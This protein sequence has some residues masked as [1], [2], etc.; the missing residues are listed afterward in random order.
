MKFLEGRLEDPARYYLDIENAKL[1]SSFTA[2]AFPINDGYVNQIRLGQLKEQVTRIVVDLGE[3]KNCHVY[4]LQNPYR[5]VIDLSGPPRN[6]LLAVKKDWQVT[7][8]EPLPD[9]LERPAI[10][11]KKPASEQK[12]KDIDLETAQKTE[13]STDKTLGSSPSD[14]PAHPSSKNSH[15]QSKDE[16]KGS[17]RC[18]VGRKTGNTT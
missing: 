13:V 7:R 9:E 15:D 17:H 2:K 8:G 11:K 6:S 1:S 18:A 5:I 3:I 12:K 14:R 4:N 16:I 10:S